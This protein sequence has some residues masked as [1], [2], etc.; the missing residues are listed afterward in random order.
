[1]IEKTK[2]PEMGACDIF[3]NSHAP[4]LRLVTMY[5][6]YKRPNLRPYHLKVS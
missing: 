2:K 6:Q 5:C 4:R 1:M 3:K